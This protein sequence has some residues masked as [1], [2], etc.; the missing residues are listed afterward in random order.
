MGGNGYGQLGNGTTIDRH[1][2]VLVSS[3]SGVAAIAAGEVHT[4]VL[5]QNGTVWAWGWN[6]SGQLGDGTQTE[7]HTPVQV[8]GLSNVTAI[9]AGS[10]HTLALKEDGTVWTWGNNSKG[11]LGDGTTTE[12]DTPVQVSGLSNVTAI[13]A[14][15]DYTVALKQDGMVWAWGNN[16]N[17][18]LGDGTTT[19]RHTPVQVSGLSTNVSAISAGDYYMAAR[20]LDGTVWAW[21]DN[22]S[23]Q[24]G[25]GTTIE[26]HTPV[27]VSGLSNITAISARG[28]F[29]VALKQDGTLWAWG[30]NAVGQLGNG[31][32]TNSSIPVESNINL[33]LCTYSF[34]PSNYG[35]GNQAGSGNIAVTPSTG[36]CAWTASTS[37]SWISVTSGSSGIGNGTVAY[38]VSPNATGSARTGKISI[39]N[40]D[41]YILQAQ[42]I[43]ADDPNDNFIPYIYA[44][45][46][47]GIT[48]GCGGGN[49]CPS[50]VVSRGQMAAF[51]I[52]AK[53]GESFTYTTTPYFSDVPDTHPFFKYVQKMKDTGIT[54]VTG[55]YNVDGLV[56]R[57]QMAAF[58]SRAFLGMAVVTPNPYQGSLQGS[59]SGTC[60]MTNVSGWFTLT[61]DAGGNV[62]G[63]YYD[64]DSDYIAGFADIS[65][66]FSASGVAGIYTWSGTIS[67]VNNSLNG[68]G[69]WGGASCS[70][71]WSGTGN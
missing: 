54:A 42:G 6:W 24:L 43:F 52:R 57:E 48:T 22:G 67:L 34:S 47:K 17:G 65:G 58:L 68:S 33:F 18:Q 2:P 50:V 20:K 7:R 64:D 49:Y 46:T 30:Y 36:A 3:L 4:V 15:W 62:Y 32:Q 56:T 28:A 25:D 37:D 71:T 8:S 23:G 19:D 5:K 69:T 61:I 1:T 26:R 70:G 13:S 12:R 44:I 39:D 31:T 40:Q 21:G 63:A 14:A 29:T 11:Q 27:Q 55:T 38:S 59:W 60:G 10:S 53:Y 35:Y 45:Y 16:G 66:S 9:A 41:I 51:I